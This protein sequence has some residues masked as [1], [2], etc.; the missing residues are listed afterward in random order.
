MKTFPKPAT[1]AR[2]GL[3]CAVLAFSGVTRAQA[4][5]GM[6]ERPPPNGSNGRSLNGLTVNG[7]T[8]NGLTVNGLTVNGLTVNGRDPN[9]HVSQ[10]LV[11]RAVALPSGERVDLR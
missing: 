11:L 5:F 10:N 9:G 1:I 8:V 7:L 6:D 3:V 2:V 4:F